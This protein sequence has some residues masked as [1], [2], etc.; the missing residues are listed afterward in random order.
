MASPRQCPLRTGHQAAGS[1]QERPADRPGRE[2]SR[3]YLSDRVMAAGDRDGLA[4]VAGPGTTAANPSQMPAAAARAS[5]QW[6]ATQ[7]S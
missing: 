6:P 5:C 2:A 7:H 3:P 4:L 1:G